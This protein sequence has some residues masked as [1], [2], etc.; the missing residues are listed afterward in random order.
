MLIKK[1]DDDDDDD[2]DKQRFAS[3]I[4]R[5]VRQGF[6]PT[7]ITNP[8]DYIKAA[9]DTLF[10]RILTDNNHILNQLL[11]DTLDKHYNLCSR[12]HNMRLPSKDTKIIENNFTNRVLYRDMY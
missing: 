10:N 6:C 7:D 3:F 5:C 4:R 9:D 1:L 12:R 8:D 2:D 11:P